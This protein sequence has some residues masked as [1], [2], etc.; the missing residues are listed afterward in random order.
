MSKRGKF[1]EGE[2]IVYVRSSGG[3]I[4]RRKVLVSVMW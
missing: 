2:E 4:I 1:T 3:V